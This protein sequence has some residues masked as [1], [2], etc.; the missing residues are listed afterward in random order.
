MS[1]P[2]RPAAPATDEASGRTLGSTGVGWILVVCGAAGLLASLVL[3]VEKFAVLADPAY[4]PSCSI[5]PVISCGSIM[6]SW[7]AELFG[8]PNPLLGVIGFTVVLTTA[9]AV[10][11]G[12]GVPRW[13][14]NG[15]FAGLTAAVAFVHW[16]I[17][18]SLYRIEALCPHCMV[19]WLVSVLGWWYCLLHLEAVQKH[20]P[21]RSWQRLHRLHA[22]VPTVWTLTV[23]ALVAHAFWPYWQTLI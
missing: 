10:L 19:V 6:T 2:T 11:A 16:L 14:W 4:R 8:F 3:T 22:V 13:Y 1:A 23:S 17:F 9:V 21:L 18:Q 7:Q 15:L 5:N 20:R 12:A